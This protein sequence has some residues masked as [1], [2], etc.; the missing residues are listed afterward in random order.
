MTRFP[1]PSSLLLLALPWL[2]PACNR[3]GGSRVVRNVGGLAEF[4]GLAADPERPWFCAGDATSGRLVVLDAADGDLEHD[5]I[6]SGGV[7]GLLYFPEADS[8]YAAVSTRNRLV[9]YD[10]ATLVKQN[11]LKL[12]TTPYALAKAPDGNLLMVTAAGLLQFDPATRTA[13]T[14]LPTIAADALLAN[15][16]DATLGFAAETVAG[17]TTVH[18]FDLTQP[19]STPIDNSATPLAGDLVGLAVDFDGALLYVGTNVSPGIH[20]L[21]AATLAEVGTIGV[22]DG[23]TGM[24]LNSTGLR[25][26]WTGAA[27]LAESVIVEPL[28]TG[29]DVTLTQPPRPRGLAIASDNQALAAWDAA[30][31]LE[32]AEIHPFSIRAPALLRMGDTATMTLHG[33]PNEAFVLF[34][35]GGVAP[36]VLDRKPVPNPRL[37]ELSF[38]LGFQAVATG[39]LD[40]NGEASITDTIPTDL[41][42]TI[43]T[44]WQAAQTPTLSQPKYT[45]SNALVIRLLGPAA[46]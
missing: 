39:T 21:D 43:D 5:L 10:P 18:R 9:V 1:H 6:S 8:L 28:L 4:G 17:A 26:F 3:G 13:N 41:T 23:L 37:L 30:G 16:R 46:Q 19:G 25:L 20:V 27:A 44:V 40:A 42:E 7:G 35:S 24:A 11:T 36:F 31:T 12:S 38:A 15:D 45:L 14:L 33:S 22:G 2:L 29:P 32:T 34:V